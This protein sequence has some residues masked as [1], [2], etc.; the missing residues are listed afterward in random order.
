MYHSNDPRCTRTSVHRGKKHCDIVI[1]KDRSRCSCLLQDFDRLRCFVFYDTR[2]IASV[3]MNA[4]RKLIMSCPASDIALITLM[5]I[6]R[7]HQWAGTL[8]GL[9]WLWMNIAK[10]GVCIEWISFGDS[11]MQLLHLQ[12]E[13]ALSLGSLSSDWTWNIVLTFI[14]SSSSSSSSLRRLYPGAVIESS[15]Q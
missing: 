12:R 1:E 4:V 13:M 14:S 15:R 10:W 3:W 7:W 9:N 11:W 5:K 6:S 2:P 8:T